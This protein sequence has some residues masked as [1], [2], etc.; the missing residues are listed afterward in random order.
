MS[1]KYIAF[2]LPTTADRYFKSEELTLLDRGDVNDG[3]SINAL[4]H[5]FQSYSPGIV[6]PSAIRTGGDLEYPFQY[7]CWTGSAGL[8]QL[9]IQNE[10]LEDLYERVEMWQTCFNMWKDT[11]F[12][13]DAVPRSPL[14]RSISIGSGIYADYDPV[15]VIRETYLYLGDKLY[16][17]ERNMPVHAHVN[18]F[19]DS[20]DQYLAG[21]QPMNRVSVTEVGASEMNVNLASAYQFC[22]DEAALQ[23]PFSIVENFATYMFVGV[24]VHYRIRA[25]RISSFSMG[26]RLY[27][28][29]CADA[30][31]IYGSDNPIALSLR[32]AGAVDNLSLDFVEKRLG[33]RL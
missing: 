7:E 9:N 10:L 5:Y 23:E 32:H 33:M 18:K 2:N 1:V 3:W 20:V 24:I 4:G 8:A 27:G 31:S 29:G 28:I 11:I 19:Y 16:L 14:R 21:L 15:D 17:V 25:P 12:A 26:V 30:Y 22:R 13:G 6:A